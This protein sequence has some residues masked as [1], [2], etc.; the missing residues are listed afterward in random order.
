MS[1][2]KQKWHADQSR[3]IVRRIVIEGELVLQTS[4]SLGGG[5]NSDLTEMPLLVDLRDGK[6]PLL[7]GASLAGALRSYV[8]T[9]EMGYLSP[10]PHSSV[11]DN[12]KA[13]HRR[14]RKREWATVAQ[15]LFGGEYGE[16]AT[17]GER[18]ILLDESAVLIDD[19]LGH[20][21]ATETRFGVRI[22]PATRTAAD[23]KLFDRQ[24]WPAGTTFPLRLELVIR[25]TDDAEQLKQGLAAALDGLARGEITL[26]GR[27]RRGYGQ[28]RV[29]NWRVR[30]FDLRTQDG[31]LAWLEEGN[32]PLTE[33]SEV[34]P[35]LDIYQALAVPMWGQDQRRYFALKATFA[36]EGSLLIRTANLQGGQVADFVHLQAQQVDGK[37]A[38]VL[39][40]TS[41][42]GALRARAHKIVS[43]VGDSKKAETMIYRM[44]GP[45]MD[46]EKTPCAS[47]LL[48]HET[49]IVDGITDRV[50]NRVS[51][52]RF[53]G[54]ARDTAL[55]NEQP[56]WGKPETC[57]TINLR[58]LKAA[59]PGEEEADQ[60][61][62]AQVGL[63]LLLLKDLWT[64]DLPLGG[65][66]SV[67]RGRLR[68]KEATLTLGKTVW[69]IKDDN[70]RLQFNGNGRQSDLQETYLN[71]FLREVS[72]D[73]E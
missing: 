38:P 41:L 26:G 34:R 23:D 53:T 50:Q 51:I 39:S 64:G 15:A 19:V 56:V 2:N 71:A 4:T 65:E 16:R 68:G 35:K 40:G 62:N 20:A 72:R 12:D 17:G 66:S 21:P 36:L 37:M 32:K 44:F 7:T 46:K 27:K 54:G 69:E 67:G 61:F 49:V 6:T 63:L 10:E 55:F 1:N 58:L 13:A 30:E 48:V 5:N 33:Q 11:Y 57:I 52:D 8:R 24:L 47:R 59:N 45:D 60:T 22:N 28:V 70:G 25:Q 43:T 9:R 29:N 3:R 14:A 31:L 73:S 18:Q 42:A